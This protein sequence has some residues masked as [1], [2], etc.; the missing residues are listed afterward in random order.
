[1]T[2]I[3]SERYGRYPVPPGL[4]AAVFE[5]RTRENAREGQKANN[6]VS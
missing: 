1:M 5:A 2:K 4:P 6:A 3:Q